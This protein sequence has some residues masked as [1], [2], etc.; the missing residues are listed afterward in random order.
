[1]MLGEIKLGPGWDSSRN[2]TMLL[3]D[4]CSLGQKYVFPT[5]LLDFLRNIFLKA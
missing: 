5:K 2:R 3:Y 1:M 4:L